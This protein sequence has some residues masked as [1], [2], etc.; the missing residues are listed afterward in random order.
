MKQYALFKGC[1]IPARVVQY[2]DAS[3]AVLDKVGVAT[4]EIPEFNC[5]GYPMRNTNRQAFLL[6]AARNLAVAQ[7]AGADMLVLCK[8][9]FGSLKM[10]QHILDGD[11]ALKASVNQTLMQEKLQYDGGLK[12]LHLLSVLHHEVGIK[13]LKENLA[14]PYQK[15]NIAVH[16]GCHALR[17]SKITEFD[18]PARPVMFDAL[19]KLTGAKSIDWSRKLDCCGAPSMGVNDALAADMMNKKIDSALDAGADY[20]CTACPYCHIQFDTM[21]SHRP[22]SNGNEKRLAPILYPQLLGISMGIAPETLGIDQNTLNINTITT[23]LKAEK[24]N[25]ESGKTRNAK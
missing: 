4:A 10:A 3:V 19:V 6:S 18:D 13:T 12:I 25:G 23:Y 1:N 15:L 14:A 5:C 20:L 22:S 8:C 21:Q 16:H 17:P 11:T 24:K 2:A 7:Q 9:C